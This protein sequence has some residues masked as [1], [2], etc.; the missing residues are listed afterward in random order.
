MGV[1]PIFDWFL[2]TLVVLKKWSPLVDW[3]LLWETLDDY[4]YLE[5]FL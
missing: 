4:E 3:H 5:M 1:N 2:S